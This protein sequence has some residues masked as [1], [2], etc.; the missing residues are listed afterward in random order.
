M[1]RGHGLLSCWKRNPH[2]HVTLCSQRKVN[3]MRQLDALPLGA[4]QSHQHCWLKANQAQVNLLSTS[5]CQGPA[6]LMHSELCKAKHDSRNNLSKASLNM[7]FHAFQGDY[8][9]RNVSS[10]ACVCCAQI[11]RKQAQRGSFPPANEYLQAAK[12]R[13]QDKHVP[14]SRLRF[15]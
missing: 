14:Q 8:W 13:A 10:A 5:L 11:I 1:S 6:A 2:K 4:C 15:F 12:Q 7:F 3:S 9:T